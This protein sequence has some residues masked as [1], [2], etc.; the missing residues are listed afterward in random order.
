[1][2]GVFAGASWYAD[3]ITLLKPSVKALKILPTICK[4]YVNKFDVLFNGK[5][6]LLIIYKCTK[7]QPP[8]LCIV[9]KNVRVPGVDEVNLLG[10]YMC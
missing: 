7:S 10:H 3:D 5:K 6:I 1:M 8:N 9:I 4:Q 2:G